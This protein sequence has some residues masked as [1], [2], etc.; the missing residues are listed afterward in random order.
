MAGGG[1]GCPPPGRARKGPRVMATV[2]LDTSVASFFHPG[3]EGLAY[4][5]LY[6]GDLAGHV[7]AVS[8]QTVAELLLWA[9]QNN[10]GA[11]RRRT[12]ENHLARMVVI[13]YDLELARTW[14]RVMASSRAAGRR[15]ESADAW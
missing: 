1:A 13:P 12:L 4:R 8:F 10:W 5:R 2:L 14:A 3:R 11:A 7:L 15:L 6:E 9:E